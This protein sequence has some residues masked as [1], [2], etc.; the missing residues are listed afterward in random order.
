LVS[1][2]CDTAVLSQCSGCE[3]DTSLDFQETAMKTRSAILAALALALLAPLGVVSAA[4]TAS[5]PKVAAKEKNIADK[6]ESKCETAPG[7]RIKQS[8]PEDCKK[9]AK[10]PFRS[11][12]K[13]ELENTGELDTG[14]AL[15][16][17][18]PSF[19]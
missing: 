1:D 12:S 10:Q 11:Y 4:D 2:R 3:S 19:R 7:S 15:R 16:K 5:A 8:K 17:L 9:L 13:K 14:E 6:D 18:D